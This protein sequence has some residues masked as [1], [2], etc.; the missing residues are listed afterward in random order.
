M[1]HDGMRVPALRLE[2]YHTL[3]GGNGPD[4]AIK[5]DIVFVCKWPES[6]GH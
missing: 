4:A 5:I 1:V 3:I 2:H 6:S